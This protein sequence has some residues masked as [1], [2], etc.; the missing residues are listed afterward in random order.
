MKLIVGLGNPGAKYELTR[1]NAGFLLLDML[2]DRFG[3]TWTSSNKCGGSVA[4]GEIMQTDVVMLK[5]LS[6]MNLSGRPVLQTASFYKVDVDDTVVVHDDIDVPFGRVKLK[7]AGGHGGHNGIRDIINVVGS[8]SFARL[9]LGVGRP[10]NTDRST[11]GW[12]LDRFSD[13]ELGVLE[14]GMFEDVLVRLASLF[15]TR[16]KS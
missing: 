2:A 10:E 3:L 14:S 8:G 12:V 13:A 6:Y 9:K 5:P 11:T 15:D 4:R 7:L 1:H 16:K